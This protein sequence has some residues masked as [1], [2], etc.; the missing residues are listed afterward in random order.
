MRELWGNFTR[1][2]ADGVAAL[3]AAP[4]LRRLARLHLT[5]QA[6]EWELG[7][8]ARAPWLSSLQWL[9]CGAWDEDAPARSELH[10]VAPDLQVL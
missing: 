8:L 5:C 10:A 2:S 7:P 4:R 6:I 1:F 9:R 3:A